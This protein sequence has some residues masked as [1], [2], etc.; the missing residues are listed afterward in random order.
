MW[1]V[2]ASEEP[3]WENLFIRSLI[4]GSL[5]EGVC[6]VRHVC[7]GLRVVGEG[8]SGVSCGLYR[9]LC[10]VQVIYFR[11]GDC[12]LAIQTHIL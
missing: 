4:W 1:V 8:L 6:A 12:G 9:G 3:V 7:L 11:A 2:Q 10:L 5:G